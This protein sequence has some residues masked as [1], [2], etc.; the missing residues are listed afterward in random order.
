MKKTKEILWKSIRDIET[1]IAK[2]TT[3]NGLINQ[4]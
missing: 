2:T 4:K 1:G 3:E